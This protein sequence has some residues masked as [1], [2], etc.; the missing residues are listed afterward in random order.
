MDIVTR[1]QLNLLIQLAEADKHFSSIERERIFEIAKIKN[2]P[3]ESVKELIKNPEPIES[4]GALSENQKFEYIFSCVDLMLIDQRIFENEV[5][6][7]KQI[8]VKLG[9]NPDVVDYLKN[10]I[11]NHSPS[12]LKEIVF[13]KFM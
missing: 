3:V 4:F 11:Q 7:C 12:E 13:D 2:F 6:F 5:R 10:E 9:F 1:K 8:A